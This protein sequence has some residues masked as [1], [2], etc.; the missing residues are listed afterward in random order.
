MKMEKLIKINISIINSI[1]YGNWSSFKN[2]QDFSILST[3]ES[4]RYLVAYVTLNLMGSMVLKQERN[5]D[6]PKKKLY[7]NIHTKASK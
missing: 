7:L 4:R 6:R 5:N 1:F 3:C 2:I